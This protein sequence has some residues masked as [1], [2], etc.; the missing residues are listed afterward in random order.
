MV[1]LSLTT[2]SSDFEDS[3]RRSLARTPWAASA[4]NMVHGPGPRPFYN[5][6]I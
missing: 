1:A 2:L 4:G 6:M 5:V 3:L